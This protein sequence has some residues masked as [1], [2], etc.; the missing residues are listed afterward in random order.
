MALQE[1]LRTHQPSPLS[2]PH[3]PT[4]SVAVLRQSE[5]EG[6]RLLGYTEIGR[7]KVLGSVE[8]NRCSRCSPHSLS[9]ITEDYNLASQLELPKVNP[10]GPSLKFIASFSVSELPYQ[11]VAGLNLIDM[12][13]NTSKTAWLLLDHC[14]SYQQ[15]PLSAVR[16]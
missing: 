7:G 6:T 8:S 2:P 10:D 14:L 13:E 5:T 4:F 12:P 11:Q 16:A 1:T 3:A 15:L 9:I